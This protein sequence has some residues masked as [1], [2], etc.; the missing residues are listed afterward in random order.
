MADIFY[1]PMDRRKFIQTSLGALGA[2][3]TIG[4]TDDL[5]AEEHKNPTTRWAFLAD[6]HIPADVNNNY[7][8]FY[9]YRNLPKVTSGIMSAAPDGVVITGDL[10]RRAG[11]LGDYANLKKLLEPLAEKS[12][13]FMALGNHD[14][15]VN[16]YKVFETTP[17]E[18][19]AIQKKHVIV[20]NQPPVRMIILDSLLYVNKVAGLL[21]KAQ[22]NWLANYLKSS[23]STPTFLFLHHTLDDSDGS[24]LDVPRL[25]KL[26]KPHRQV[27][28]IIYGHS[29]A[30]S[31]SQ[32]DGIHLINLPAVGYNFRNTEPVGWVEARLTAQ[33]G[34]FKLHAIAG[35][36]KKDGSITK[37][38]WRT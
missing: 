8:G 37:L 1:I 27:K 35:D 12:P 29:H 10:A 38:K 22:R 5:L 36:K 23:D 14:N 21:G 24:L 32:W 6:T 3:V 19:Q 15:R 16:F 13:V 18:R 26:I 31:F 11:E 20:L 25:F 7:R 2:A 17:G 9:P 33:G 30:Y 4:V 34:E 28:G